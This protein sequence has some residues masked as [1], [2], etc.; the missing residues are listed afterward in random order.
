MKKIGGTLLAFALIL[1]TIPLHA[2]DNRDQHNGA[3]DQ[4]SGAAN[5]HGSAEQS[6]SSHQT[7]AQRTPAHPAPKRG[8][9]PYR[10]HAGNAPAQN[11]N[12]AT[13]NRGAENR[14]AEQNR[15]GATQENRGVERGQTTHEAAPHVDARGNWVGH[16]T[17]PNDPHYRLAHPFE[18]GHFTAGFGP[19]HVWHLQGGGP[20][21]FW[22]NNHYFSVAPYD[23]QFCSD[24]NWNSDPVVIYED[25]DHPG[26]Y[27]AY[28]ERTGAY[29]HVQFLG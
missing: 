13:E 7:P 18:H 20:S 26:Y 21:R 24:W 23:V 16:D 12:A 1:F 10:G 11:T 8:P 3:S 19:S 22:F 25:P 4:H 6:P 14:N 2:Q 29:V 5:Q 28:N 9:Q 17:G 15:N 27:L